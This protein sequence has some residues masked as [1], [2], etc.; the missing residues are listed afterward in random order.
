MFWL[1]SFVASSMPFEQGFN[2]EELYAA[3]RVRAIV[4]ISTETA[5]SIPSFGAASPQHS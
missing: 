4:L 1:V 2:A 5:G 3:G